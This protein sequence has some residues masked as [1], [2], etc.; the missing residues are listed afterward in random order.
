MWSMPP[1]SAGLSFCFSGR[2]EVWL[3]FVVKSP[4]IS[5][6]LMITGTWTNLFSFILVL[7]VFSFVS[8][9]VPLTLTLVSSTCSFHALHI[10]R[11]G[12]RPLSAAVSLMA[13]IIL[14]ETVF[15]YVY[16]LI[17]VRFSHTT[18]WLIYHALR[19]LHA[20]IPFAIQVHRVYD[21]FI[22]DDVE[23]INEAYPQQDETNSETPDLE[24]NVDDDP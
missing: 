21:I 3:L 8:I 11:F 2:A 14:P 12:N 15:W 1:G 20:V 18:A 17:L 19:A 16:P 24:A 22:S 23:V 6:D 10:K 4:R 9:E 7:S 5:W 13:S